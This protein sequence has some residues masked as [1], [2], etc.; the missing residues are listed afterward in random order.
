MIKSLEEFE[1]NINGMLSASVANSLEEFEENLDDLLSEPDISNPQSFNINERRYS[2]HNQS[3]AEEQQNISDFQS[4]H[5]ILSRGDI[6]STRSDEAINDDDRDNYFSFK[7]VWVLLLL[8]FL[9]LAITFTVLSQTSL[10]SIGAKRLVVDSERQPKNVLD[11]FPT[12]YEVFVPKR[13]NQLVSIGSSGINTTKSSFDDTIPVFFDLQG[14]DSDFT[15]SVLTDCFQMKKDVVLI[16]SDGHLG[17]V[18]C[19][20]S[21]DS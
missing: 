16:D 7:L 18:S 11:H 5:E 9:S 21:H 13:H 15:L 3:R 8:T 6:Q 19:K 20:N 1:E 17:N 14:L 10:M 2:T 4:I 12:S